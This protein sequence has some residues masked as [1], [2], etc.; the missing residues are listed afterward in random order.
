MT[1]QP[2][3]KDSHEY[4]RDRLMAEAQESLKDGERIEASEQMWGAVTHQLKAVARD[5]G[6]EYAVHK[7]GRTLALHLSKAGNIPEL[8]R[9]YIAAE[10]LHSNYYNDTLSKDGIEVLKPEVEQLLR[11]LREAS[12]RVPDEPDPIKV[13]E[14]IDWITDQ[15]REC[16]DRIPY[17]AREEAAKRLMDKCS[18]SPGKRVNVQID[19]RTIWAKD[20]K[21]SKVTARQTRRYR[22]RPS[23]WYSNI[24]TARTASPV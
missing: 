15:L 1:T 21:V 2:K 6:W 5:H 10:R 12:Q 17:Q 23:K 20:G 4:H 14:A 9:R 11:D 19:D 13:Q 16:D 18:A 22:R 8:F 7:D 3:P 24:P